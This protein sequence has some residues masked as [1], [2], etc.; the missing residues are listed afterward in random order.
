VKVVPNVCVLLCTHILMHSGV[1]LGRV[2]LFIYQLMMSFAKWGV[3]YRCGILL[4]HK[5]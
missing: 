2:V 4:N 1:E 5:I 3:N